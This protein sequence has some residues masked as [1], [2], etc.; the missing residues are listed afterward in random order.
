MNSRTLTLSNIPSSWTPCVPSEFRGEPIKSAV[1][2]LECEG[3]KAFAAVC[4]L[5]Q[6]SQTGPNRL[7]VERAGQGH[8][9]HAELVISE[10]GENRAV[11]NC[12]PDG[13]GHVVGLREV[14]TD[15][16]GRVV[17]L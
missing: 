14:A 15:Q 13:H 16:H 8:Y 6:K 12:G 5:L 2:R 11:F 3:Q 4:G 7:V 9:R 1:R 17:S 10:R